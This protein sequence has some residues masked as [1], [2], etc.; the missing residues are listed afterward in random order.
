MQ[1]QDQKKDKILGVQDMKKIKLNN[2][3]EKILNGTKE[4]KDGTSQLYDGVEK[5]KSEGLDKI[6]DKGGELLDSIDGFSEVKDELVQMTKDYGVYSG[7]SS[8]MTGSVKFIMRSDSVEVSKTTNEIDTE[9]NSKSS[10]TD[11]SLIQKIKDLFK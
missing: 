7:L 11:K 9:N 4:L 1:K 6:N 10:K 2:N 5:L 3:S 8:N